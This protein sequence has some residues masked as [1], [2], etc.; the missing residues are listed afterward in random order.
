[1]YIDGLQEPVFVLFV[2]TSAEANCWLISHKR[3]TLINENLHTQ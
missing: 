1:M 3:A 2:V